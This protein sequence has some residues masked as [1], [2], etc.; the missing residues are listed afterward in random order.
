MK[1]FKNAQVNYSLTIDANINFAIQEQR[2]PTLRPLSKKKY[3]KSTFLWKLFYVALHLI[4]IKNIE[5]YIVLGYFI[6]YLHQVD[7]NSS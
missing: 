3:F 5:F 6:F 1:A 4:F 7:L 2:A